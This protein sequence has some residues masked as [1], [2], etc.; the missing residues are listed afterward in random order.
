MQKPLSYFSTQKSYFPCFNYNFKII[1]TLTSDKQ[2]S[3][4]IFCGDSELWHGNPL[5]TGAVAENEVVLMS[6][7]LFFVI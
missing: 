7:L 3:L 6:P 5:E 2:T 4:N 1:S